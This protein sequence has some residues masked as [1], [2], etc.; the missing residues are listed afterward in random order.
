MSITKP[1]NLTNT[2]IKRL[3]RTNLR[4]GSRGSNV[5]TL[6]KLLNKFIANKI[7]VDGR[8]GRIT[9]NAVK[10]FQQKNS[11][12][13]DGIVGK[14]T[15]NSL[16][17]K[18][19]VAKNSRQCEKGK[20]MCK[21]TKDTFSKSSNNASSPTRKTIDCERGL[22]GGCKESHSSLFRPVKEPKEFTS[23]Q[24]N[25]P[26]IVINEGIYGSTF[27]PQ[28][29]MKR[30]AHLSSAV[31]GRV[32]LMTS[33]QNRSGRNLYLHNFIQLPPGY[34]GPP[35]RVKILYSHSSTTSQAPYSDLYDGDQKNIISKWRVD[36]GPG[37]KVSYEALRSLSGENSNHEFITVRPGEIYFLSPLFHPKNQ[38]LV[39]M[40]MFETQGNV[41]IEIAS[42]YANSN[43]RQKALNILKT[44]GRVDKSGDPNFDGRVSG[45]TIKG[46]GLNRFELSNS[47]NKVDR[48]R[49][50]DLDKQYLR[51]IFN[52]D[53]SYLSPPIDMRS[54]SREHGYR[55]N[56][57]DENFLNVAG[58]KS[59]YRG[60]DD[61]N[62]PDWHRT[63]DVDAGE[64]ANLDYIYG[65]FY[66]PSNQTRKVQI[67]ISNN[68]P[69]NSHN[70]KTKYMR[71][72]F[73][74]RIY[75]Q[76][77][78]LVSEDWRQVAQEAHRKYT[79][80]NPRLLSLSREVCKRERKSIMKMNSKPVESRFPVRNGHGPFVGNFL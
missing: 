70:N 19:S 33:A 39:T 73:L 3:Y 59:F 18:Y 27:T 74:V 67:Y 64:Y 8:F 65:N 58:L 20:F 57:Y 26:E 47:T 78:N 72:S 35:V 56:L 24:F 68:F 77:S 12:Y 76:Q 28:G 11:L 1:I 43:S 29:A 42:V 38:E 4:F 37:E 50:F 16:L 49:F 54:R 48:Q 21:R 30:D 66:N 41:P 32:S 46:E 45:V 55:D 63:T 25:S 60:P 51:D 36:R 53:E 69:H 17:T 2:L 10:R 9:E 79:R 71:Q 44:G 40:S 80:E 52:R 15:W 61:I 7:A 22:I 62:S 31:D 75:N 14:N 13:V 34:T 23:V 5:E 6:Q